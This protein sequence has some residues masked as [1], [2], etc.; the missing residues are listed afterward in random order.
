MKCKLCHKNVRNIGHWAREH[1]KWLRSRPRRKRAPAKYK[2]RPSGIKRAYRE[3]RERERESSG[4]YC[5]VCG[6][7]H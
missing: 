7:M 5:P 6:R 3:K 2:L 1:K 4:H